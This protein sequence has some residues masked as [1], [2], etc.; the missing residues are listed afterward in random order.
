MN[1]HLDQ[2]TIVHGYRLGTRGLALLA[3]CFPLVICVG[4]VKAGTCQNNLLP[5]NP[6]A[7]YTIQTNGTVTDGRTG[8]MW[9]ACSEGQIWSSSTCAGS[10]SR[11]TWAQAMAKAKATSFAGY[12]DWR[13]PNIK[14]LQ[15]LVEECRVNP[16]INETVFPSTVWSAFWSSSPAASSSSDASWFVLFYG[17]D[18][19]FGT[20]RSSVNYVRLVRAGM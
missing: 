8:L 7:I 6:D 1:L 16:S 5:S 11:F 19:S 4:T 20:V 3:L 14:E 15:T 2:F 18:T 9:K 13:V 10:A 17:G 12:S